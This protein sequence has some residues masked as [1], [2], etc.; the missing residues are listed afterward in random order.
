MKISFIIPLYNGLPLTQAMLASLWAT[1]TRDC[2]HEIILVDDG[3]A[4]GTREWLSTLERPYHVLL[5]QKN[6]GFAG[7]CNRGAA[8][9]SGDLIFFLNNDLLLLPGWLEP[10]LAAFSRF[11]RAGM[12]GNVQLNVLTGAIDHAG[13]F[14]NHKGKPQ[15]YRH[16]DLSVAYRNVDAVTGACCGVRHTIWRQL[17]G[18]DD[19]YTNGCED[20]DICLRGAEIGLTNYVALRSIIRHH[21]SASAGRKLRDEHNTARLHRRWRHRIL[22]RIIRPCGV[23]CLLASWTEPRDYPD[24]RLVLLALLHLAGLVPFPPRQLV[25]AANAALALEH[26]RWENLLHGATCR[27]PRE[28]AWQFFPIIP[29]NPPVI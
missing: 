21:I 22:P 24:F 14:F 3:S 18:F 27:S 26:E 28:I 8:I 16:R 9:A 6:L 23:A 10:M 11:P 17:G 15:H 19:G 12:V 5:N 13:I 7:A 20:V 2:I 1:V 29:E 25:D 4:D